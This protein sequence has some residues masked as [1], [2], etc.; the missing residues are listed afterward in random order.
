MQYGNFH[1]IE[2][3]DLE[4]NTLAHIMCEKLRKK[5]FQKPSCSNVRLVGRK[6]KKKKYEF[7]RLALMESE[8]IHRRREQWKIEINSETIKREWKQQKK[9]W[10]V[11]SGKT[12][13]CWSWYLTLF[14]IRKLHV[15][16]PPPPPL[17]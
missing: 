17:P 4:L 7:Y 12:Y 10:F 5:I 14:Y 13:M 3:I 8:K 1:K 11:K 16:A 2:R 9:N 6:M 15:N